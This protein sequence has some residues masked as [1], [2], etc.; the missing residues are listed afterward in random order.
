M[1]VVYFNKA[2][3]KMFSV[4]HLVLIVVIELDILSILFFLCRAKVICFDAG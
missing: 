3:E 4:G 1:N 2:W